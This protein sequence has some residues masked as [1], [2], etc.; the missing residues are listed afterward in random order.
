MA[1]ATYC[2]YEKVHRTMRTAIVSYLFKV[3]TIV[4]GNPFSNK[5]V[6]VGKIGGRSEK[7]V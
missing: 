6:E 2:Y 1:M 4:A 3:T 7:R 5:K